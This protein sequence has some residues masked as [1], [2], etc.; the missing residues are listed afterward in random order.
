MLEFVGIRNVPEG[1]RGRLFVNFSKTHAD[2]LF[3]TKRSLEIFSESGQKQVASFQCQPTGHLIFEVM[4]LETLSK[5]SKVLGTSSISL[6]SFLSP[7]SSLTVEKWLDV[8]PSANIIESTTI[9]LKVAIS[10]A[11]PTTAPYALHMIHSRLPIKSSCLFPLP[12][13]VASAKRWTQVIDDSGNE[14]MSLQMRYL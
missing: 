1:D 14:V 3:T 4:S 6:E 11:K 8:V 10:V 2:T 7:D 5:T 9:A 12:V 13:T